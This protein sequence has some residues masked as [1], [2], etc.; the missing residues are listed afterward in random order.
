MIPQ[1][2]MAPHTVK[3][4]ESAIQTLTPREREELCIW[5]DQHYPHGVDARLSADLAA[6][7]LDSA[8][9]RA[10]EEEKE[11]RVRPL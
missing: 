7:R 3:E 2:Y 8:I 11:G 5:L 6:G 1:G 9:E 4:I 10:L